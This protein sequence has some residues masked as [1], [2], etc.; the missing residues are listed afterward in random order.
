M[1]QPKRER[2]ICMVAWYSG[3]QPPLALTNAALAGNAF[4]D[5]I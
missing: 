3:E 4:G 1:K 5:I 2:T